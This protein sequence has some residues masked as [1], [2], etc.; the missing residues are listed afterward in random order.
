[1]N[2]KETEKRVL[3]GYK[4]RQSTYDKAMRRAKK[5][6]LA[7]ATLIEG[8]VRNY[9]NGAVFFNDSSIK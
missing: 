9:S 6:R 7:L 3:K 1:M 8:W 5:E 2:A 4:I